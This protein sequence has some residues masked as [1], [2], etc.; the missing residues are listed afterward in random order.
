MQ[1]RVL[2]EELFVSWSVCVTL[3][4]RRA[5]RSAERS[6][7]RGI[8]YFLSGDT[9]VFDATS[10]TLTPE[11]VVDRRYTTAA[12]ASVKRHRIHKASM[13]RLYQK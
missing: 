7:N 11:S 1:R 3:V 13:K 9:L 10:R 6:S 2:T 8:V 5:K 4:I 12:Y